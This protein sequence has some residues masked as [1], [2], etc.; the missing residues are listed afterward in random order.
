MRKMSK[1]GVVI[2]V[3]Q[4]FMTENFWEYYVV[5][6]DENNI[7]FCLVMGMEN[8]LGYVDLEEIEPFITIRSKELPSDPAKGWRWLEEKQKDETK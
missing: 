8:E 1:G 4:W 2:N 6:I 5:D 7:A 3:I